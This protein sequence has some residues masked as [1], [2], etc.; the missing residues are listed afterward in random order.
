MDDKVIF[1]NMKKFFNVSS[2]EDVAEK[3]GY[4]RNTASTWRSK[5]LTSSV[6]LKFTSL[7]VDKVKKPQNIKVNLRYFDDVAASAGYGAINSS[8][9]FSLIPVSGEFLEKVLKVP[10]KNYDV[11]RVFGDSMEPFA[12]NGDMVII[13]LDADIK[14]GDIIIANIGGDVYM[15][16]FLRNPIQKEI[17]LTSLNSF[18]QD[19]VLT[20]DE[21]VELKIIGKV[22]C[23]FSLDM[24]VY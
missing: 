23:K 4:S 14:N 16:K 17:K 19:I 2:L 8:A 12:Q 6:K 3:M 20:E 9:N 15:K 10:V 7:S 13:D 18:Y 24:K 1:E 22:R 5:G 21:I 11:I